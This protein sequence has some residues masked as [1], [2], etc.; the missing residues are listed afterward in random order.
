MK[1]AEIE[2]VGAKK[3]EQIW[4]ESASLTRW[5]NDDARRKR[6][7]ENEERND[8]LFNGNEISYAEMKQM[9]ED[10]KSKEAALKTKKVEEEYKSYVEAVFD[11]VYNG[12]EAE[13]HSLMDVYVEAEHLLQTSVSGIKSL[14]GGDPP[15]TED[16]LELLDAIYK[17]VEKRHEGVVHVVAERDRCYKKTEIQPLYATGKIAQV[18]DTEKHFESAEKQAALK[19]KRE[20]ARR[21]GQLVS[22]AEDVV[23]NALSTEQKEMDQIVA[24]IKS[25]DDGTGDADLLAR[26]HSTLDALKRSSKA[27]LTLFNDLEVE[28]NSAVM[29]A[30]IA[31]AQS[32]NA[33]AKRVQELQ[34]EKKQGEKKLVEEYIR[35]VRV[36]ESDQTELKELVERKMSKGHGNA[37][38]K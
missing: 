13:M 33:D 12:L 18:R 36:L 6:Q 37:D 8:E 2:L 10:F 25:L 3:L 34:A 7:D 9:E 28:L 4:E 5:K 16:C 1:N 22:F 27:L 29:D 38:Q 30:D 31:E 19:A 11:P 23:V 32:Q 20:K 21:I 17:Q 26:A 14:E 24:A 35:R 15:S